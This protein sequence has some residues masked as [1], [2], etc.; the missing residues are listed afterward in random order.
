MGVFVLTSRV[1]T[2]DQFDRQWQLTS[3]D[4]DQSW[5]SLSLVVPLLA[6]DLGCALACRMPSVYDSFRVFSLA[7]S[8]S[9][10]DPSQ[11][12]LTFPM[13][14]EHMRFLG[15]CTQRLDYLFLM[16]LF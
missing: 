13:K 12:S 9:L 7:L 14:G 2:T 8:A 6:L 15:S 5:S 16:Y 10:E 4:E 3:T 1:M 11:L